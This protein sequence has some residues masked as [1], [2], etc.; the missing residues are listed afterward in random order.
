MK[1][2]LLA[3]AIGILMGASI[4]GPTN[5]GQSDISVF[6]FG[7]I[8]NDGVTAISVSEG[9]SED[10]RHPSYFLIPARMR[11]AQQIV[12]GDASLLDAL[13]RRDIAVHNVLWVQTAAN[14]GK[15]IY[16]R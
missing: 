14:G 11:I 10:E 15:V 2:N 8:Y 16:Y 6:L 13:A 5:A 12:M 1:R 3:A 9:R 7:R 4:A